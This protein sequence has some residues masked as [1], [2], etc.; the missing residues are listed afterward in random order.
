MKKVINRERSQA[1]SEVKPVKKISNNS[2]SFLGVSPVQKE[3][4]PGH[5]TITCE[6]FRRLKS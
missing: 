3:V 5:S 1:L 2:Q 4:P 6:T